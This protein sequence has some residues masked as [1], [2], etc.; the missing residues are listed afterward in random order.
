MTRLGALALMTPMTLMTSAAWAQCD[1][2]WNNDRLSSEVDTLGE[3][4]ENA[5]LG[6]SRRTLRAIVAGI[7]CLDQ[8]IDRQLL[9]RYARTR[10]LLS[11]Y[12]QDEIDAINWLLLAEE[13]Q[14]GGS[15]P[16]GLPQGHPFFALLDDQSTPQDKT[17]AGG[18]V[19]PER[20]AIFID[21]EFA[22]SPEVTHSV[23]H[24]VQIFDR[25]AYPVET[26]WQ[27]GSAFRPGLVD[28]DLGPTAVPS[29]Y[30]PAKDIIREG[31]GPA[32]VKPER[33]PIEIPWVPLISGLTLTLT[34]AGTYAAAAGAK[35]GL[36]SAASPEDL[37]RSRTS[38]NTLLL[39]SGISMAG[40]IGV[41][42]GSV[43]L[44]SNG[45]TVRFQF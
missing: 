18:F 34:S 22:E 43:M 15:P 39:I 1:G 11:F 9:G 32:K 2:D 38:A 12:E 41:G 20:G 8:R 33:E 25:A 37:T 24:L 3:Q 5:D 17:L 16:G 28:P 21:G 10:G 31:K 23:P 26:F 29:W 7:P 35:N 13:V 45:A 27:D 44:H 19:V 36:P 42:A 6:A 4:L 30:D 14:P 40:A